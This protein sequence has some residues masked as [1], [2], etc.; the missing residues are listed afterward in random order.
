MGHPE[1]KD[2]RDKRTHSSLIPFGTVPSDPQD[3]SK[4]KEQAY[5]VS[6]ATKSIAHDL[7]THNPSAALARALYTGVKL[8]GE[9]KHPFF[10]ELARPIDLVEHL[11][12]LGQE[13]L[14]WA[15]ETLC[16]VID[17]R[18]GGWSRD[19]V[20]QALDHF[21]QT[22][23]LVTQV[24]DLVRQKLYALRIVIT[25]DSAHSFWEVFEKVGSVFNDRLANFST[26]QALS[27]AEC[28][29]TLAIME[30][31]R[32]DQ[33]TREVCIYVAACCHTDGLLTVKPSKWLN[34]FDQELQVF[35]AESS[36]T[37]EQVNEIKKSYKELSLGKRQ[38]PEDSTGDLQAVKLL[39]I[40]AYAEEAVR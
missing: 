34:H 8:A 7:A 13:A 5:V 21:H 2:P 22:G 28:A 10:D 12:N 1:K 4:K 35:N 40:D 32:P 36:A 3:K 23:E 18:Y 16:S 9:R 39:G 31:I 11:K 14:V 26:I 15:P 6:K 30:N 33:Y 19:K 37:P 25:S 29:R 24:P 17:S 38:K 27:S 20:N